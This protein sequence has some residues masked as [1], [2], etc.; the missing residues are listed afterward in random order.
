MMNNQ[1]SKSD[2]YAS[3]GEW[4]KNELAPIFN[5]VNGIVIGEAD[6]QN[7]DILFGHWWA[8]FYKNSLALFELI[9]GAHY[10]YQI[11]MTMRWLMEVAADID[12]VVRNPRNIEK[13]KFQHR[14]LINKNKDRLTYAELAEAAKKFRLYQTKD[15]KC[16]GD[17]TKTVDR[18]N[19]AYDDDG[20][21]FYNYLNCF[22]HFNYLG[23]M[24]DLNLN[25]IPNAPMSLKERVHLVQFYPLVFE[26]M[27]QSIGRLCNISKLE[28]YDC[29]K[30]EKVIHSLRYR[31]RF[32]MAE[33]V[34]P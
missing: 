14:K 2:C 13:L 23:V 17:A 10:S 4:Y 29:S 20:Q 26:M 9:S 15:G 24:Y 25:W 28:S 11:A 7:A 19:E 31:C 34:T 1:I 32:D 33:I 22:S 27:V 16:Y 3:F 6:R 18:I 8:I 21:T 5:E 12:F 30:L